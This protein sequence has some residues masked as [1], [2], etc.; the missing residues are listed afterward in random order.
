MYSTGYGCQIL[1]KLEF[2]GHIFDKY[3]NMKFHENPLSGSRVVPCRQTDRQHEASSR[4]SQFCEKPP[5]KRNLQNKSASRGCAEMFIG[6][7]A[8]QV[9]NY[10]MLV[11]VTKSRSFTLMPQTIIANSSCYKT[12]DI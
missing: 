5:T 8:I 11:P 10:V 6:M 4:F 1:M 12:Y 3:S 2:S 7:N 9:Q